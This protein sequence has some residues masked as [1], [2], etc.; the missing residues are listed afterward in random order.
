MSG[1]PTDYLPEYCDLLVQRAA[2]GASL[3]EFCA[4]VG[5]CRQTLHNWKDRHSEFLDAYTRAGIVGQAYWEKW[6]RTEGMMDSKANAPLV[7]LYFANRFGWSD[8]QDLQHTSPDGSMS[9]TR[10]EIVPGGTDSQD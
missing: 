10:I 9:P 8:K 2:E 6:L 3:T 5:I 7:K 4:E 1:R